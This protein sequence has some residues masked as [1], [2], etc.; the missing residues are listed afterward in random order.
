[1]KLS[2][3]TWCY[4]SF[5]NW[6]PAYP[7]DY[8]IN[9]IASI[10]YDGIEIGCAAPTAY[11]PYLSKEYR[12]N[13]LQLLK[14]SKIEVS[15]ALPAPGGGCGNNVASPIEAERLQAIQS[16]KDCIDLL[17]DLE[18]KICIYVAGWVIYGVDQDQAWEWSKECLSELADYAKS[19]G[20]VIAIEPTPSDSNLIETAYDAVK[21]M[22][23]TGKK[24]VGV[25]FDTIHAFYRGDIIT[26]YVDIMNSNLIHI[27][28]SDKERMPPGTFTDFKPLVEKLK[29]INYKGYLAME[30]ALGSRGIDGSDFALKAFNYMKSI[31]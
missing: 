9:K 27:H 3:N 23:E 6:L 17:Y 18:G 2:F 21:L 26:D 28:I 24:N 29:S 8:V 13:I 16:Y 12:K 25:M 5:P 10:G 20:I 30:I 31:L 4:C 14:S 1:M 7:L 22:K 11:P 15:S 19:K